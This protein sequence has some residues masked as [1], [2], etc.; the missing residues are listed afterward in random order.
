MAKSLRS[1]WR[2]RM[3]AAKR[4]RYGEKETERLIRMLQEAGDYQVVPKSKYN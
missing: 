3:R 2:R 1:K 4:E